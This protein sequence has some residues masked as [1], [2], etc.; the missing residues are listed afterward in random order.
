M[1]LTWV[2]VAAAGAAYVGGRVRDLATGEERPIG[3]LLAA[4]PS[5]IAGDLT[6]VPDDLRM[7]AA[8]GRLAAE[9][10]MHEIDALLQRAVGE[11]PDDASSRPPSDDPAPI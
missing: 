11:D 8:E 5:R 6:T 10:R 1:R 2:V 3:E 9:R 4:L 7:A